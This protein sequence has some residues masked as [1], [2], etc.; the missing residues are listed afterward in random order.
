MP[1]VTHYQHPD[2]EA[3]EMNPKQ[4]LEEV[5]SL[6]GLTDR[7]FQDYELENLV[8]RE[9]YGWGV[10]SGVIECRVS[11]G[12]VCVQFDTYPW[13]DWCDSPSS[14]VDSLRASQREM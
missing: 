6:M 12:H 9:I 5:Q 3:I 14:A 2:F 4:I 11:D 13:T 7:E 10:V 1:Q 8:R